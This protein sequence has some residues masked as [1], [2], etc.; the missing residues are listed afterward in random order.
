[1][2]SE[3]IYKLGQV[4]WE[5]TL[6]CNLKCIHCGSSAGRAR[7]NEL[8]TDE[9]IQLCKDLKDLDAQEICL[10]GGEPFLRKDWYI[11]AKQVRDLKMKLLFISNGYNINKDIISKLVKLEPHS[12]STSLDGSTPET[13]DHIR[14]VNGSFDKVM[15]YISL[16]KEAD[17]PTTVITTVNKLNFKEL[18]E[19]RDFLLNKQI[20][21]QIQ[22]ATPEGRFLH[23]YALSKEEYYSAAIFIASL[24]KKYTPKEMPVVGAHCFGYHSRHL[25]WLG[26]YPGWAGCQAGISVL[27]IKS[28]GDVIGCLAIPESKIEGN[29]REKSIIDIWNSPNSFAY[30]RKFK[31]DYLGENCKGCK[32]GE[33]CKGGCSGMSVGFTSRFHN[34]PYCF[35]KIEP[36]IL[37]KNE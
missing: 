35:Y 28:N 15:E 26:L 27:S 17:L 18:P 19:L 11:I 8:S 16:S 20:A 1:M 25:P 23:K 9:A 5:T 34:H 33:T 32:F 14:G 21:W 3:Q 24:K 12:V 2:P 29:I 10:M 7:P 4:V 31:V 37:Q 22:I 36:E 6:R 13:H 30:T